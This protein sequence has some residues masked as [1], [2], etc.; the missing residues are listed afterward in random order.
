M[1][2]EMLHIGDN[3]ELDYEPAL[4]SNFNSVLLLH[5][6]DAEISSVKN[7]SALSS[8]S[9][10]LKETQNFVFSLDQF[11]EIIDIKYGIKN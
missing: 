10:K 7:F 2:K 9:D 8:L 3:I 6:K 11:L 4:N 1:A 5:D